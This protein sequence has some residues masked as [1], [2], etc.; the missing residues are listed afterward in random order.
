MSDEILYRY[1]IDING[2]PRDPNDPW[3]FGTDLAVCLREFPVIRRTPCGAW[4]RIGLGYKKWTNTVGR[5]RYAH[6]TKEAALEAF[7][8]RRR[9]QRRILH[10]QIKVCRKA[11]RVAENHADELLK[12]GIAR[13]PFERW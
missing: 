12:N 11:L 1:E 4:L 9:K 7:L 3:R 8:A 2:T 10:D 6:E 5:K 13:T